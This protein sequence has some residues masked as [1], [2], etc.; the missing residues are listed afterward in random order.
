M[1]EDYSV[2]LNAVA[3]RRK[4]SPIRALQQIVAANPSIIS[5]GGGMPNPLLFPFA[6]LSVT[7]RDGTVLPLDE[8]SV[9]EALQYSPTPGL[10]G[11]VNRLRRFQLAE[12]SPPPVAR[13]RMAVMMGTGSQD[14]IFK[15][16]DCMLDEST[17]VIIEA[18]TYSGTLSILNPIGCPLIPVPSAEDGSG[19]DVAAIERLADEL[20]A[21]GERK[22]RLIYVIPSA[23]NPTGATMPLDA[24]RRLYAVAQRLDCIIVE[25]DPYRY[26]SFDV[27]GSSGDADTAASIATSAGSK[28]V[29]CRPP[30]LLSM[31]V[32]GRV[33]RFDSFSKILSAGLRLG[34]VTGPAALLDAINLHAQSSCLHPSGV[35]Q[36]IALELFRYW[37]VGEPD[38]TSE[39][40]MGE[41]SHHLA[42]VAMFYRSQRDILL[43]AVKE[44]LQEE[45]LGEP[46][47]VP[48]GGMFL[49]IKVNAVDDTTS[50]VKSRAADAGVLMVPGSAFMPPCADDSEQKSQFVRASFSVASPDQLCEAMRRFADAIRAEREAGAF[51]TTEDASL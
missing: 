41:M 43:G 2:F 50:L 7:L 6:G 25:D 14:L 22:P 3:R 18:P 1:I 32:D 37:K 28:T 13:E 30:S 4:P 29:A 27:R 8:A 11:L 34:C 10:P 44:H 39:D 46:Y 23:G 49:W 31:D 9:K 21:S 20:E 36:A 35:S 19:I 51:P 48:D 5:L 42:D 33:L 16:L 24:R 12:H 40:H 17:P 26:L 45:G 38:C 47:A 15:A